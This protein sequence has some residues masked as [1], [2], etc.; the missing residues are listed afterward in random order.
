MGETQGI[1]LKRG[2][3]LWHMILAPIIWAVHFC[4]CYGTAAVWC[5][6][7]GAE[8]GTLR[9]ILGLF[10][11]VALAL[12]AVVAWRAWR[13]WNYAKGQDYDHAAADTEN[14][15]QFL[16][17]AGF[18]LSGVSAVGVIYVTLPAFLAGGCT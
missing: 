11:I 18:L 17:H 2:Q 10:T 13:R 8:I 1:N 12:I 14:R 7:V 15:R 6:K 4:L 16:G 5:A 9:L 3:S